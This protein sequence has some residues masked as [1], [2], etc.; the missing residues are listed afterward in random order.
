MEEFKAHLHCL[1]F[2]EEDVFYTS[3]EV[4]TPPWG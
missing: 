2:T 1:G 3:R 4:Q